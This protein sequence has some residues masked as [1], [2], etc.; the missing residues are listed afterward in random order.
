MKTILF[1]LL[2]PP[3]MAQTWFKVANEGDTVTSTAAITYR[4]G[5]GTLWT[6][7]KTSSGTIA[8]S[9]ATFGDPAPGVV[10]ELD[11]LETSSAQT[12]TVNG[13]A[14][15]VP[16]SAPSATVSTASSTLAV[17]VPNIVI[18][19]SIPAGTTLCNVPKNGGPCKT[20][21]QIPLTPLTIIIPN[22][23][24]PTGGTYSFKCDTSDPQNWKCTA[25]K[26]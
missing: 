11:V 15:T 12:V 5:S 22:I 3:L 6:A 19:P 26:Q 2:C 10:K 14:V 1:L 20:P 21:I 18:T 13:S 16:A 23:S 25:V 8:V 7:P 24:I 17:S 9:N 4:Y